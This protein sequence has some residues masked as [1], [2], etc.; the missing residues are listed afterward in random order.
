MSF[1]KA[2]I[3]MVVALAAGGVGGIATSQSVEAWYPTL[4]KPEF[5]P[6][7]WVF[8]PVWTTLYLMMGLAAGA[9]WSLPESRERN[10]ALGVYGLQLGLNVVWSFL[11]FGMRNPEMAFYE[12][13]ALWLAI[14]A[15]AILFWK[16]ERWTGVILLPYLSWV[17]FASYLNFS[18]WQLNR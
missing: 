7:S 4:A 6:P 2:A 12:I 17:T 15:T 10:V 3:S 11:F 8:G 9:I 18:I 5:N 16:L 1:S 14:F 13:L